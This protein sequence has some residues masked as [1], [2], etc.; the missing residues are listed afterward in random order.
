MNNQSKLKK[1]IISLEQLLITRPDLWNKFRD[2][3]NCP[4]NPDVENFI[5]NTAE[6]YDKYDNSKTHLIL[7]ADN[8]QNGILAYYT[9]SSKEI[10][11]SNDLFISKTKIGNL[12]GISRT[13]K[14]LKGFLLGQIGKNHFLG[15]PINL[16]SIFEEI[17]TMVNESRKN[18]GGRLLFLECEDNE[19]L[20]NLYKNNG[21]EILQKE[22]KRNQEKDF[23]VM[24]RAL[25]FM[26]NNL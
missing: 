3:F 5:K 9:L 11:L 8:L 26:K 14:S 13:T 17:Y 23:V 12:H 10:I 21:F 2:D 24:F 15:N 16:E 1:L 25:D 7:D 20:I 18:V 19:K 4:K 6:R 22:Y